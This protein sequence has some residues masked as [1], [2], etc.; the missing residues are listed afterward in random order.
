MTPI[1]TFG[2]PGDSWEV[3]FLGSFRGSGVL[4]GWGLESSPFRFEGAVVFILT[5]T[6]T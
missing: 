1:T 2:T 5:L 4:S 3:A 6:V